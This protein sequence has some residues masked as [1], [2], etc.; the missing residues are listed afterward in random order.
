MNLEHVLSD[1]DTT[2]ALYR[3]ILGREPEAAGLDHW[4]GRTVPEVIRGLQ[5]S[6]EFLTRQMASGQL[7]DRAFQDAQVDVFP[8]LAHHHARCEL[9]Q[10]RLPGGQRVLDLGGGHSVDPR[11]SLLTHGYPYRPAELHIVDLPPAIRMDSSGEKSSSLKWG[12]TA[13]QFHYRSMAD[14]DEFEDGYFD[15]VWSGESIEHVTESDAH[16]VFDGVTRVLKPGGM[17]CLDTPNRRLTA[18]QVG[19]ENFIHPEH[20]KEYLFEEFVQLFGSHGLSLSEQCGIVHMPR[21]ADSGVFDLGEY[22]QNRS[23]NEDPSRSYM[24]YLAYRKP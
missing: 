23:L 7:T 12:G 14:L 13:I 5:S 17:F 20:K 8:W 22:K 6:R 10:T 24:F 4:S 16:R 3:T 19:A 18:L 2:A 9:I 15:L 1:R 21:S 11:G